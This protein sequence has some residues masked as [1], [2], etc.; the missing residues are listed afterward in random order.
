MDNSLESGHEIVSGFCHFVKPL[1]E[2]LLGSREVLEVLQLQGPFDV[3][4]TA[5]GADLALLHELVHFD[6][7]GRQDRLNREEELKTTALT[8]LIIKR[9]RLVLDVTDNKSGSIVSLCRMF[10]RTSFRTKG[11][12]RPHGA[13]KILFRED[14]KNM[15]FFSSE[16]KHKIGNS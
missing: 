14:L 3:E 1:F 10:A 6:R 5:P 16:A 7:L 9:I 2:D 11:K 13:T 12:A 8:R 15:K 4:A